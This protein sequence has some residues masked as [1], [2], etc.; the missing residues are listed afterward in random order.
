[1]FS[2]AKKK[3][4][5]PQKNLFYA[6]ISILYTQFVSRCVEPLPLEQD[7]FKSYNELMLEM[8]ESLLELEQE[9]ALLSWWGFAGVSSHWECKNCSFGMTAE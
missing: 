3:N 5:K 6:S 7:L 4:P 9:E 2:C 1:M 8:A